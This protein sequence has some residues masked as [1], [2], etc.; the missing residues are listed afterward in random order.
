M[1]PARPVLLSRR[2]MVIASGGVAA[3]VVG[4]GVALF[5]RW[6]P[7]EAGNGVAVLPF[8]NLSG[9]PA[10]AYFSDGLAEEVRAALAANSALQV[11][12]PTSS[13]EFRDGNRDGDVRAIGSALGVA[14]LLEGSVR[15]D[16]D[17]VRVV[18]SL[19]EPRPASRR[20][21]RRS[22]AS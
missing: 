14:H 21:R 2:R 19:I 18:S 1:A 22:T 15:K 8:R 16:G 17:V 7:V 6:S 10:Q 11:A 13:N 20:G 3:I 4:G 9:D 5:H 12:A